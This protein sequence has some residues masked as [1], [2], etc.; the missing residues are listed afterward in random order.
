M[1]QLE[2]MVLST[3]GC[4]PQRSQDQGQACGQCT[5]LAVRLHPGGWPYRIGPDVR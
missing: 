2:H 4:V 1:S 5:G 3:V